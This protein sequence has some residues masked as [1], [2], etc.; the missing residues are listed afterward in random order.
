MIPLVL[1]FVAGQ[2]KSFYFLET[3][4]RLQVENPVTARHR[5]RSRRQIIRAAA[6]EPLAIKQGDAKLSGSAVESRIY[7]EDPYRNFLPS[8]GRLV[9]YRPPAEGSETG[10]YEAAKFRYYDPMIAKLVTHADLHGRHPAQ[11]P[12]PVGTDAMPVA[13]TMEVPHEVIRVDALPNRRARK[14]SHQSG[15]R[16]SIRRKGPLQRDLSTTRRAG[17]AG[18]SP[19]ASPENT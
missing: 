8:T 2:D 12:I 1:S 18:S 6:G 10:V 14:R 7:A 9:K 11:H 3:N 4:T 13:R 19:Y 16:H 5:H 15:R 17:A